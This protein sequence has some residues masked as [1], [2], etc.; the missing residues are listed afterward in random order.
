ML[1]IISPA[2]SVNFEDPA[3][4]E[5]HTIPDHLH[6]SRKLVRLLK[7]Y[8]QKQLMDLMSVSANIAD[9]NVSR[10]RKFKTPFRLENAKQA[11]FA[12][13]GDVYRHMRIHTYDDAT[14]EFAQQSLRILS[15]LYGILRPLDLI[16]AYRLEMKTPLA[17]EAGSDLYKFWGERL[18]KDLNKTLRSDPAPALINL[19][20]KEYSRAIN[21]KKI[22]APVITIDFKEMG[23]GKAKVISIFAKW[24]RGMMTDHIIRN[25]INDPQDIQKFNEANYQFSVGDSSEDHWVFVR[26][27]P[28]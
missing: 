26:P 16:Q 6:Q 9:L 19:A 13:Q 3:P 18:T 15:G 23:N 7:S 8:D 11:L 21:L 1:T 14:L 4:V 25:R 17:N 20:S 12:F 10:F 22:K 24:A 27:R 28:E 5:T 2:K